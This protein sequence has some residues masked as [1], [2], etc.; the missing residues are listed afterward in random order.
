MKSEFKKAAQD[1][2]HEFA[3]DIGKSTFKSFLSSSYDAEAGEVVSTFADPSEEVHVAFSKIKAE[4]FKIRMSAAEEP[5]VTQTSRV[6][7]IAGDDI[8]YTPKKLD[9]I[10]AADDGNTYRVTTVNA[11]MYGALYR[12]II[13]LV[14]PEA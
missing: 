10:I 1:V 2:I 7:Y 8:S 11:D 4:D 12:C 13:D 3:E 14:V 5:S 9:E 6:A